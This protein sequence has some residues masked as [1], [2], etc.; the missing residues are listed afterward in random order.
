MPMP[1]R[2][3][4]STLVTYEAKGHPETLMSVMGPDNHFIW[5]PAREHTLPNFRR[6]VS[7]A[8]AVF[9]GRLDAVDSYA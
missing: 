8:W 5:L 4:M 7:L 2:Y 3:K 9:T 6:R 1:K